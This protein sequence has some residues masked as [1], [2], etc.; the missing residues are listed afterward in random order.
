MFF[1]GNK[2]DY[3]VL[4]KTI[5]INLYGKQKLKIEKFI[6]KNAKLYSIFRIAKTYGDDLKDNTLVSS[7][8]K[9]S[10]QK[11]CVVFAA[12]DQKFSPLFAKDIVKITNL[13]LKKKFIGTFNIGGPKSYSRYELYVKFNNLIKKKKNL[14]KVKIIKRNLNQFKFPDRRAKDVS[15]NINKIRKYINFKLTNIEDVLTKVIK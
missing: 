6:Q 12:S 1:D 13:F 2:G 14:Y 7:F 4:S 11:E 5:S 10:K 3:T 15:F 9:K 8:L